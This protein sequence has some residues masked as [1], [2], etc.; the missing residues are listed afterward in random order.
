[1]AT[2][3]TRKRASVKPDRPYPDFPLFPHNNGQ[4]ARKIKGKLYCFGVWADP[5]AALR[6]YQEQRDDLYA[7]RIPRERNR[8][9]LRMVDAVNAF[10]T[11][12]DIEV[13]SGELAQRSWNDYKQTAARVLDAF[14]RPRVVE[15][16]RPE[17][18][19]TFKAV[20]AK[21]RNLTTI[22]NEIQRVR[23]L[24]KY[25]WDADL[26]P[27]PVK[28]GPSFK[29][30]DKKS[31]RRLRNQRQTLAFAAGEVRQMIDA[32]TPNLKAMILLA[33]NTA[34]GNN[35]L[36]M[37]P[38]HKLDL[39]RGWHSF[40]RPKT[41]VER[42]APL[43]KET[44]AALRKVLADRPEPQ[45]PANAD[46]VFLTRHGRPYVRL[47]AKA[48]KADVEAEQ[49]EE[50][51]YPKLTTW[52]DA[53]S[54][55]TGKL[56]REL[57]IHRKGLN[58]YSLRRT[59]RTIAD[60]AGDQPATTFLMGHADSDSDMGATYRQYID[61]ERLEKVTRHVH[62]W[63]YGDKPGKAKGRERAKAA[64]QATEGV[65]GQEAIGENRPVRLR[66][67]GAE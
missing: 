6:K 46:L 24:F 67:V 23:C 21:G 47:Q 37:L 57:G 64:K 52:N 43:W 3:S 42:R 13:Q 22:G 2:E 28:F 8:N 54:R 4:W 65:A 38:V 56:L 41:G 36:A 40:G 58:F 20:L 33:M 62:A 45:D 19:E 32:A 59:F 5:D 49:D 66:L 27:S 16:L 60:G 18:F 51:D 30:P 63:L 7:G 61:D 26:I 53:I 9:G 50:G 39:E 25:L 35:D 12:K 14:G 34:M 10:L 1:M 17:D 29:R 55:E 11:A 31:R 44:V 15:D 48:M